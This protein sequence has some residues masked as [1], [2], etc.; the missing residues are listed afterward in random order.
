M[1]STPRV[2]T[3]FASPNSQL[4]Q[5]QNVTIQEP[6]GEYKGN[7]C[8]VSIETLVRVPQSVYAKGPRAVARLVKARLQAG[9]F[10]AT[11][12]AGTEK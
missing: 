10:S 2:L 9:K 1:K 7:E 11:V 3:K 4:E 12:I 5:H 6:S 8:L